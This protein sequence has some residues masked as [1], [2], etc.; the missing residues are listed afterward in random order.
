[1]ISCYDL[2]FARLAT[3]CRPCNH[4]LLRFWVSSSLHC[5]YNNDNN[6]N[7]NN[8]NDNNND[9]N[10]NNNNNNNNSGSLKSHTGTRRG[11]TMCLQITDIE[12]V[13]SF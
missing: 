1:M 10:N 7:N 13:Y 9:N 12:P 8:N 11:I 3:V 4:R 5:L 2:V 6:D